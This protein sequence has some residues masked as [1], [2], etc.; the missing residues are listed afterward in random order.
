MRDLRLAL[1]S[2]R[3]RPV[4]STALVLML[5]LGI[6]VNV[7]MFALVYSVLMRPLPFP[8]EESLVFLSLRDRRTAEDRVRVSPADFFDWRRQVTRL[9]PLAAMTMSELNVGLED[10]TRRLQGGVVTHGFFDALGARPVQGRLFAADDFHSGAEPV[11]VLSESFWRRHFGGNPSLA[12]RPVKIS[13][14]LFRVVGVVPDEI[15]LGRP[16]ELWVPLA[17]DPALASRDARFLMALGRLEPGVTRREAQAE[18]DVVARRL[19]ERFPESHSALSIEVEPFRERLTRDARPKLLALWGTAGFALLLVVMN[20]AFLFIVHLDRQ[21]RD[22]ALHLVLGASRRALAK[23]V[24]SE[25]LSL[26]L[27]STVAGVGAAAGAVAV[28]RRLGPDALPGLDRASLGPAVMLYALGLGL[29]VGLAVGVVA[30]SRLPGRN[31]RGFVVA[32]DRQGY[33]GGTNLVLQ[34]SLILLQVALALVLLDGAGLMLRSL[35]N[36]SAVDPGFEAPR[37]LTVSVVFPSIQYPPGSK[38]VQDYLRRSIEALERIPGAVHVASGILPPIGGGN[39]E[40]IV[41][42]EGMVPGYEVEEGAPIAE[43]G[44][45]PSYFKTMGLTMLRG[46]AF[47]DG[48]STVVVVNQLF[49]QRFLAGQDPLGRRLRIQSPFSPE[50][51]RLEIVGVVEPERQA[52]LKEDPVPGIYLPHSL[53]LMPFATF[54]VRAASGRVVSPGAVKKVLQDMDRD[55]AVDEVRPMEAILADSIAEE[56]TLTRLLAACAFL[57]LLLAAIGVYGIM[58]LS[59]GRRLRELGIRLSLGATPGQISR[60]VLAGGL[61][62]TLAG[63]ALGAAGARTLT[64]GLSASL[65]RVE[66]TDPLT[67]ASVALLLAAATLTA[68]YLPARKAG[69]VDPAVSLRQE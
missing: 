59:V 2:A 37:L 41:S 12:G 34:K 54:F 35:R 7:A 48:E 62:L 3:S 1:R 66:G 11:V 36:L 44:V 57:A 21:R 61:G 51:L 29:L 17:V 64:R 6:G 58:S 50:P 28:L 56:R 10:G 8:D 40:R 55:V 14:Q 16:V 43:Q 22:F 9:S 26:S 46:R 13:G 45:S 47:R 23:R 27:L 20:T 65:F 68:S 4:Y 42:V 67:L 53:D 15:R 30:L 5:T 31:L 60:S 63:L 25:M 33:G 38:Q 49:A 19:A 52:A 69:R 24:L 39:L 18:M 32:A